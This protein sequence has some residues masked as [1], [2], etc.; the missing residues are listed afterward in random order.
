MTTNNSLLTPASFTTAPNGVHELEDVD[1]INASY[2]A[3]S[4][5]GANKRRRKGSLGVEYGRGETAPPNLRHPDGSA[6]GATE[7]SPDILELMSKPDLGPYYLVAEKRWSPQSN[8]LSRL[9][10]HYVQGI[11]TAWL[12]RT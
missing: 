6:A 10:S 7:L 1:M 12:S 8:P 2:E 5:D 11:N 3:V 9:H 4:L